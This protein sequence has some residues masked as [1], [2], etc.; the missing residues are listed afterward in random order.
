[1]TFRSRVEVLSEEIQ[2]RAEVDDIKGH[3]GGG[4]AQAGFGGETHAAVVE[5]ERGVGGGVGV[6]EVP[7]LAPPGGFEGAEAHDPL[8]DG[9]RVL[10]RVERVMWERGGDWG[11]GDG[12]SGG[13]LGWVC[14]DFEK[15]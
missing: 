8:L 1:M 11:R 12:G 13:G 2:P 9:E 15:M 14:N 6:P 10:E 5:D 3:S 7:G 4:V